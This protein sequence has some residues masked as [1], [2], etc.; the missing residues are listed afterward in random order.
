[1]SIKGNKLY[2]I[3]FSIISF[4]YLIYLTDKNSFFYEN[5]I[6][7]FLFLGLWF[8]FTIKIS[9]L[10]F[11]LKDLSSIF[12]EGVGYFDHTPSSYDEVMN[13]CSIS[14][15]SI[16]FS[17]F[18]R[19]KIFVKFPNQTNKSTFKFNSKNFL[20]WYILF[21]IFTVLI[22][23]LN[24]KFSIHQ[25]GMAPKIE[26]NFFI[27]NLFKWFFIIGC[28]T[29]FAYFINLFIDQKKKLPKI[30]IIIHVF[31]EFIINLSMLSRGMIFNS[32][33]IAWGIFNK[34]NYKNNYL[35]KFIYLI[36]IFFLFF[37]GIK[38]IGDVR[39]KNNNMYKLDL[40]SKNCKTYCYNSEVSETNME[41]HFNPHL[42]LV[43]KSRINI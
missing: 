41:T 23:Y 16:I 10:Y 33:S 30:L 1:M 21:F 26:L 34:K 43:L 39:V 4:I 2:Y 36:L 15:A 14:F 38:I 18:I 5:F 19:R 28:T 40:C 31:A 35:F 11:I 6:S 24:Y 29:F 42:P 7:V 13:V 8:N 25:R 9:F 22:S 20:F 12:P 17:S 27:S 32:L 3:L 37:I